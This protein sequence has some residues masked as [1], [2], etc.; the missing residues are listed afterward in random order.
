MKLPCGLFNPIEANKMRMHFLLFT[1]FLVVFT[2]CEPKNGP[3]IAAPET[4]LD[5]SLYIPLLAEMQLL[6]V[7]STTA[8]SVNLED[9]KKEVFKQY[10]ISEYD[11]EQTHRYN[12]SDYQ[13]QRAR[14]DSVKLLIEAEKRRIQG[15]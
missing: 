13:R 10:G 3:R 11:F 14:L 4:L 1:L 9:L 12:Q 2:A 15:Y 5:D 6:Q 8:D 7:W